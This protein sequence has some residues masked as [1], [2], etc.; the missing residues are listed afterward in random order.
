[1]RKGRNYAATLLP[2][3]LLGL[4]R[5]ASAAELSRSAS[6]STG[7]RPA[8]IIAGMALAYAAVALGLLVEEKFR[9]K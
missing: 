7:S 4:G 3:L 8:P 5:S 6:P 2:A 1:M 9:H